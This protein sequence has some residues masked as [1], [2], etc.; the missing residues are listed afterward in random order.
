MLKTWRFVKIFLTRWHILKC[1]S[2]S[3]TVKQRRHSSA[4][5]TAQTGTQGRSSAAQ[6][7]RSGWCYQTMKHSKDYGMTSTKNMLVDLPIIKWQD[8]TSWFG[9]INIHR[10]GQRIWSFWDSDTSLTKKS[11]VRSHV[12]LNHHT[13]NHQSNQ[14]SHVSNQEMFGEPISKERR[15]KKQ[16]TDTSNM[17]SSDIR[18]NILRNL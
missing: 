6:W 10:E 1:L 7:R 16:Q 11:S 17:F 9:L 5:E 14:S 13:R 18:I 12:R 3:T 15:C 2:T 8:K 4:T